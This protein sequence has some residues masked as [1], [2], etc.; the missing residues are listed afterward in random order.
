MLETKRDIK[1]TNYL[2]YLGAFVEGEGSISVSVTI[3]KDFKSGVNIQ[4]I[5]NVTPHKNGL[6]ILN[7]FK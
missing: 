1:N 7:S 6:A 3:H 5:F 2:Y 4:P